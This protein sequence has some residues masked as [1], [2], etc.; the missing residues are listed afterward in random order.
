MHINYDSWLVYSISQKWRAHTV[1]TENATQNYIR[2]DTLKAKQWNLLDHL[3]RHIIGKRLRY[4]ESTAFGKAT[5]Q[6]TMIIMLRNYFEFFRRAK[7][8]KFHVE[9]LIIRFHVQ[10]PSLLHLV[11]KQSISIVNGKC[12]VNYR[13]T[14]NISWSQTNPNEHENEAFAQISP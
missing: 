3:T 7:D 9:K 13:T 12:F 11:E 8:L 10:S 14:R 4:H 1:L 5:G 6:W 2:R